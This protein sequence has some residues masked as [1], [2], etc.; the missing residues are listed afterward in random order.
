MPKYEIG[1]KF[2]G[3]LSAI[4]EAVNSNAAITK[5]ESMIDD[6]EP[7]LGISRFDLNDV[8]LYDG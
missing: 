6:L 3:E 5:L 7:D 2:S 1:A 8:V 4:I